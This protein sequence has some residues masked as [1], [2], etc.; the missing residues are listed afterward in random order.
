MIWKNAKLNWTTKSKEIFFSPFFF[1]F[2]RFEFSW[3]KGFSQLSVNVQRTKHSVLAY[4]SKSHKLPILACLALSHCSQMN[5][6]IIIKL[7][8]TCKKSNLWPSALIFEKNRG[9]LIFYVSELIFLLWRSHFKKLCLEKFLIIFQ[10][11]SSEHHW[12]SM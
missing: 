2:A 1:V 7:A 11:I 4:I 10:E 12:H 5:S 8:R 6:I 3:E 9:K